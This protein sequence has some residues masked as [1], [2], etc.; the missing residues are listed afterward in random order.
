MLGCVILAAVILVAV[1]QSQNLRSD[2]E[3]E[4]ESEQVP[5]G[6][7]RVA[8][9]WE[10]MEECHQEVNC[11]L[12]S[13]LQHDDS[14]LSMN[15]LISELQDINTNFTAEMSQE[16]NPKLDDG[17]R[18]IKELVGEIEKVVLPTTYITEETVLPSTTTTPIFETYG[19]Y[20]KEGDINVKS[21]N[22][23]WDL[24]HSCDESSGLNCSLLEKLSNKTILQQIMDEN[25]NDTDSEG[26]KPE[27]R[28]SD[29]EDPENESQRDSVDHDDSMYFNKQNPE[30]I[31]KLL[32]KT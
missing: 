24:A 14:S 21:L 31:D 3:K 7:Q 11:S 23:L 1:K 30:S 12:E 28:I 8:H 32:K 9:L 10:V 4:T 6:Y 27:P 5:V 22:Q 16:S 2:A 13:R 15:Q 17:V 18:M 20:T 26:D 25:V 29:I 19:N